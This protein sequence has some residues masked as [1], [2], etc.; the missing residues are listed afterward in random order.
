MM[1]NFDKDALLSLIKDLYSVIGIRISVFDDNFKVVTE[2]PSEAPEICSLI[3]SGEK[4]RAACRACD[5]AA[6]ERAKKIKKPHVYQCHAGITEAITPIQLGGGVI[7]YAIFA[8][9]LPEDNLE[10]VIADICDRCSKFG[11]EP[12]QTAEAVKKLKVYG[13]EQIMASMRLLDAIASYLQIIRLASWKNEE[14]ASQIKIF[15]ESNL[16]KNL[17]SDLLCR[18]FYISRTALYSLSQKAFGMGISEYITFKRMEKAK[19]LIQTTD[20]QVAEIACTV[21][22]PD[23]N[24]FSKMFKKFAGISP[25]SMRKKLL[26]ESDH[27]K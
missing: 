8:H 6:C 13:T 3:R 19:E 21:G 16:D 7:G 4:G 27:K 14:I 24:H 2:Y 25:S 11:I 18:H 23:Y 22:I 10:K 1:S 12:K 17:K 5:K 26:I 20:K 9:L 15:I